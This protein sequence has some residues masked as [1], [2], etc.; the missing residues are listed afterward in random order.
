MV[1]P[2]CRS[3]IGGTVKREG[4]E[5][6]EGGAESSQRGRRVP[7][8]NLSSFPWYYALLQ[9]PFSGVFGFKK[10]KGWV[11]AFV[12]HRCNITKNASAI[13]RL[14]FLAANFHIFQFLFSKKS[15]TSRVSTTWSWEEN[16]FF[17]W[18]ARHTHHLAACCVALDDDPGSGS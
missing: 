6:A 5:V 7:V 4:Q 8:G 13:Q 2:I 16:L 14:P 12:Y 9:E 17:V 18:V 15:K 10:Q 11:G 1:G 3:S